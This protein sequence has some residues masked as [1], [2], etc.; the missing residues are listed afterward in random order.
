MDYSKFDHIGAEDASED[1]LP[2]NVRYQS[3][4][5]GANLSDA[6]VTECLTDFDLQA[7]HLAPRAA[8]AEWRPL[9]EFRNT[10]QPEGPAARGKLDVRSPLGLGLGWMC[11]VH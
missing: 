10:V 7:P 3:G 2:A 8:A 9:Q 11:V 5:H 4:F 6:A 1:S